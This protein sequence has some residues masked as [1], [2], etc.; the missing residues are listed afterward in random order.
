MKFVGKPQTLT[1]VSHLFRTEPQRLTIATA[2]TNKA[3]AA[4]LVIY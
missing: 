2:E 4:G 1:P 3:R